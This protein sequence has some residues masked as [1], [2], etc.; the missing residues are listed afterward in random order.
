VIALWAA[1]AAQRQT[2]D[3]RGQDHDHGIGPPGGS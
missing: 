3:G 1:P 2:R